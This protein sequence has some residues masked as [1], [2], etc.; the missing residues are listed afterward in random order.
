[1]EV[2]TG[3][4]VDSLQSWMSG[5]FGVEARRGPRIAKLLRVLT[6]QAQ[7]GSLRVRAVS[8][9]YCSS[10]PPGS[11]PL[12]GVG[13]NIIGSSGLRKVPDKTRHRS[14]PRPG[15]RANSCQSYASDWRPRAGP[16]GEAA[17]ARKDSRGG[18]DST[19]FLEVQA[20]SARFSEPVAAL[21]PL[22]CA[23]AR[24]ARPS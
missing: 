24:A 6:A 11:S 12:R 20:A 16:H 4:A 14:A 21:R 10:R 15:E 22:I 9:R 7:T 5:E 13:A 23:P 1:M 8:C 2:R 17:A 3:F 18:A 19:N